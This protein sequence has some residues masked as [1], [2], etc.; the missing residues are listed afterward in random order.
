MPPYLQKSLRLF[1]ACLTLL[2][3]AC[4]GALPATTEPATPVESP[5]EAPIDAAAELN[6]ILTFLYDTHGNDLEAVKARL[7]TLVERA[8]A[9][10]LVHYNLGLLAH[11]SAEPDQARNHYT[12]ALALDPKLAAAH[13][14]LGIL[15][16]D[17]NNAGQA[18]RHFETALQRSPANPIARQNLAVLL[19]SEEHDSPPTS[20]VEVQLEKGL[21]QWAHDDREA[22]L[23]R[24]RHALEAYE[25]LEEDQQHLHREP[26]AHAAFMLAEDAHERAMALKMDATESEALANQTRTKMQAFDDADDLYRAVIRLSHP[27]WAVAAL[28]RIG[29]GYRHAGEAL[30]QTATPAR[31]TDK[32]KVIY[33]RIL[34]DRADAIIEHAVQMFTTALQTAQDTGILSDYTYKAAFALHERDPTSR[35]KP[36][37]LPFVGQPRPDGF[38]LHGFLSSPNT[39]PGDGEEEREDIDN[40]EAQIQRLLS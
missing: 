32:Q 21:A 39:A 17:A 23:S 22:A 37:T 35:A 5:H 4:A 27:H 16:A 8:P 15:T 19:A 29:E 28:Y 7:K 11:I 34:A 31:L 9:Y 24:F 36:R 1:A 6:D 20:P 26:A 38:V 3:T 2:L 13:I 10:A 12:H 25:S 18:Q 30:P 33:R 40:V 14:N